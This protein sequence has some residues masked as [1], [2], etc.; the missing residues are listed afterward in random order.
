MWIFDNAD[1][2]C[3]REANNSQTLLLSGPPEREILDA[4]SVILNQEIAKAGSSRHQNV[5]YFFPTASNDNQPIMTTFIHTLLWQIISNA[6]PDEEMLSVKEFLRILILNNGDDPNPKSR[7]SVGLDDSVQE[8]IF[9][10]IRAPAVAMR[11]AL[12]AVMAL[13]PKRE[14]T[15]FLGLPSQA[16]NEVDEFIEGARLFVLDLFGMVHKVRVLVTSSLGYQDK[17][18]SFP[19]LSHIEFDRERRGLTFHHMDGSSHRNHT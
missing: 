18:S 9:K 15:I 11:A 2:T 17:V 5:L 4:V 16:E 13:D 10:I 7:N 6:T 14:I 12:K 3:W 8:A 19:L 1:F